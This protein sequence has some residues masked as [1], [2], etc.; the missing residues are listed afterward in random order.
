MS[1]KK[2]ALAHDHL[3]QIGG[4]EKVLA[5]LSDLYSEA[6][7]YTLINSSKKTEKILRQEKPTA[8]ISFGSY[9]GVAV[10]IAAWLQ[11]IPVFLHEQTVVAGKANLISARFARQIF[12]TWEQ[13]K[14][15]FPPHKSLVVGLPLRSS[16]LKPSKTNKKQSKP[17][18]LVL[19]GKQGSHFINQLIFQLLP[20]LASSFNL[21]HQTGTSSVTND[22]QKALELKQSLSLSHYHPYGYI[23]ENTIGQFLHQAD[24][25]ISRSGAH[26]TYELAYL[27]KPCILIPFEYTHKKEQLQNARILEKTGQAAI[28]RQQ[29]LTPE[30]L[31]QAIE[32]KFS[33][34]QK[35]TKLNLPTNASAV[36]VK[37]VLDSLAR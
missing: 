18:I 34:Q 31:L 28:L 29:N 23:D 19:G 36:I 9:L 27:A 7:I 33:S 24:L 25:V 5:V 20:D 14:S 22:Y 35:I 1:N 11:R 8:V 26:T 3:F 30:I 12:L 32:Q 4:A 13:S 37:Q 17:T 21:I 6:P 15:Y 10:V 2:I 16:I